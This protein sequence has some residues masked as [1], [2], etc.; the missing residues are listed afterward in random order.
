MLPGQ[1]ILSIES[2]QKH[3]ED[4]YL[5]TISFIQAL[6]RDATKVK[7]AHCQNDLKAIAKQNLIAQILD[8]YNQEFIIKVRGR[9]SNS[10][11]SLYKITAA[12]SYK[13]TFDH[14]FTFKILFL[15]T[16]NC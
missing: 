10:Q 8:H 9:V 1:H 15:I 11:Y 2:V 13:C 7:L 3:A 14:M 16:E 5:M 6:H 12:S 4:S